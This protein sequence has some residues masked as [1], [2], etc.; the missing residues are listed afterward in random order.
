MKLKKFFYTTLFSTVMISGAAQA[1]DR[2]CYKFTTQNTP[3]ADIGDTSRTETWCYQRIA[4]PTGA[5]YIYNVDN[6]E[7]KPEL[8]MVVEPNGSKTHGSM[9]NGKV[10]V[11]RV[12]APDFNPFPVPTLE[13]VDGARMLIESLDNELDD[14]AD[15]VLRYLL[16]N[17]M[18]AESIELMVSPGTYVADASFRP[19]RGYWWPYRGR[20]LSG[21]TNS[22]LAKWDRFVQNRTGS[23]PGAAAWE[24]GR[25]GYSGAWWNGHCNGWAASSVLRTQPTSSKTVNGV[26]FTVSDLKGLL[27][28]VDYCAKVAFFGTR[29]RGTGQNY[30]DIDPATFHKTLQYYIGNLRKPVAMDYYAN[31]VVDNHVVSGYTMNIVRTGT[32]TFTVTTTL[33][34]HKYDGFI[35]NTPGMAPLYTRVYK[36]RLTQDSNGNVVSGSW[37]S[38]NPDFVWV[39]LSPAPCS[40]NNPRID[41]N[42]VNQLLSM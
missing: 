25:H 11:H 16:S 3:V 4:E 23:N 39:P 13:P 17:S 40:S 10:T 8:A 37:L 28:E 29:Y 15:E 26:T 1:A 30:Y 32:N 5:T 2:N 42:L 24:N 34:M 36:Y 20:P 35:T 14:K 31:T 9:L 41:R 27:A 6:G 18:A 38:A 12:M 7:V 21:T 19:W 22:P 33:R